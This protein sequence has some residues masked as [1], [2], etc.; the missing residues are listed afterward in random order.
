MVQRTSQSGFALL[1]TLLLVVLA[2]A[3][4]AGVTRLSGTAAL[5]AGRAT[6]E[7]Q[8]R[9]ATVSIQAALLERVGPVLDEAEESTNDDG[10][11]GESV[12]NLRLSCRLA[13]L[14]YQLV[15]TDEQTKLNVNAL[16]RDEGRGKAE[17]VISE[18]TRDARAAIRPLPTVKLRPQQL[19]ESKMPMFGSLGQIFGQ[20][21]PAGLAGSTDRP[22]LADLVTCWGDGRLN[23]HRAPE[24]V[25]RSLCTKPLGNH[26][27]SDL[28]ASREE[29]RLAEFLQQS[30]SEGGRRSRLLALYLTEKSACFGIWTICH[31]RQRTWYS[32]AVGLGPADSAPTRTFE[33]G[34]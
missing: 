25:I 10:G 28:L 27:V 31:G 6:E 14:D 1:L 13:D 8:R 5:D 17:S 23:V 20:A 12:R 11:A 29:G 22:G 24:A 7:L 4:L 33:F 34:W 19:L 26:F 18:L 9:W 15:L 2:A 30:R 32:L 3:M 16:L 21:P